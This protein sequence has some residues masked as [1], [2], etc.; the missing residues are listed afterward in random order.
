MRVGAVGVKGKGRTL[1]V[2]AGVQHVGGERDVEGALDLARQLLIDV[3]V[4]CT[5]KEQPHVSALQQ[6]CN[7]P[8]ASSAECAHM[9]CGHA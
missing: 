6:G 2:V 8:E 9:Y 1:E 5:P 4:L 7:L 3:P